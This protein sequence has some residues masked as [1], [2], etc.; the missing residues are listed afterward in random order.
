MLLLSRRYFQSFSGA[1]YKLNGLQQDE[2]V[3]AW[4]HGIYL[5]IENEMQRRRDKIG[6]EFVQF[7]NLS[8][9]FSNYSVNVRIKKRLV[10]EG[11]NPDDIDLYYS[12]YVLVYFSVVK[13]TRDG[14]LAC[15]L[16]PV[17]WLNIPFLV[18]EKIK[19]SIE[20]KVTR[21]AKKRKAADRKI[22]VD[23]RQAVIDRAYREYQKTVSPELWRYLPS[24]YNLL[25]YGLISALV[26]DPSDFP[27]GI[28][29]C[30]DAIA[31]LPEYV[32]DWQVQQRRQ[33][34]L[35]VLPRSD[36]NFDDPELSNAKLE[37]ATSVFAC[38]RCD[39]RNADRTHLFGGD[40]VLAHVRCGGFA[41]PAPFF[42]FDD[43]SSRAAAELVQLLGLDPS[44]ASIHDMDR[45]N[46]RFLCTN[47]PIHLYRGAQGHK[48]FTWREC[49]SNP[50]AP[51]HSFDSFY[52]GLISD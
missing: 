33:I 13:L 44:T 11:H 1:H 15:W 49:V 39:H 5:S 47:C 27:L 40:A 42:F 48:V 30:A 21:Q 4:G 22:V 8:G 38:S 25:K 50:V 35:L 34:L 7:D 43:I 31:K 46:A 41:V 6:H 29:A 36:P 12:N 26:N 9:L 45:L 51:M 24:F 52:V 19:P 10:K 23:G 2:E 18:W 37:L 14:E 32:A 3:T 28:S 20:A 17:S 16:P